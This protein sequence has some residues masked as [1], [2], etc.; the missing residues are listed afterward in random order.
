MRF[1]Q[2]SNSRF[3]R[4]EGFFQCGKIE[5]PIIGF[6]AN[7]TPSLTVNKHQSTGKPLNKEF[8]CFCS[9]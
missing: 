2:V 5:N 3:C 4:I 1:T 9:I 8:R 6:L 7:N